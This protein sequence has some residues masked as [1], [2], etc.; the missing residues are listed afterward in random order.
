MGRAGGIASG[1]SKRRRKGLRQLA[2]DVMGSGLE[3][4]MAAQVA[5]SADGLGP[6]PGVSRAL[7]I[8]LAVC[9]VGMGVYVLRE[10]LKTRRKK[11]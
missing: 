6:L 5:A 4:R 9:W 2:L 11:D 10:K 1:A 7:L 3:P 8:G